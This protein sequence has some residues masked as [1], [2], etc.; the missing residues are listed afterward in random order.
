MKCY[1]SF[2]KCVTSCFL[3]KNKRRITWY[4]ITELYAQSEKFSKVNNR[5]EAY[6]KAYLCKSTSL[7]EQQQHAFVGFWLIQFSVPLTAGSLL[8]LRQSWCQKSVKTC[9]N[10]LEFN[11]KSP[12]R[13]SSPT[14]SPTCCSSCPS[15]AH[16]REQ[17]HIV[18]TFSQRT[19]G[20]AT[21]L[22]TKPTGPM[23]ST[24]STCKLYTS[25]NWR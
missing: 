7:T 4:I 8:P 17:T 20:W 16:P 24:L 2:W 6:F 10:Q 5:R 12:E 19:C 25:V 15:A 11:A 9:C 22:P 1:F 23:F 21:I 13:P 3:L 18:V 14:R